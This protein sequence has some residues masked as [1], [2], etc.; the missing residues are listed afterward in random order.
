MMITP[1]RLGAFMM[2]DATHSD[3]VETFRISCSTY[4]DL[5]LGYSES[6]IFWAY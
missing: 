3:F 2:T 1:D 6:Y 5:D 4:T